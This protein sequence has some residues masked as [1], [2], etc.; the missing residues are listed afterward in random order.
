ML[1][2]K[3]LP[4][5]FVLCII[6]M[7]A[8]ISH[9]DPLANWV[10]ITSGTNHWFYGLTYGNGA[11]VAVG[12]YGT[13]LTSTDGVAWTP[14]TSG[15]S[16][17]LY[18]AGFGNNTFVAVGTIGTILTSSNNGVNWTVRNSGQAHPLSQNL[19]GVTYGNGMFVV[20][21]GQGTILTSSD[22]GVTWGDPSWPYSSPT[23]NWLYGVTYDNSLFI[24]VGATGTILTSTNGTIWNVETSITPAHLEG[25]AYG[26]GT[27]VAVG[28][29]GIIL[30]SP[31]GVNWYQEHPQAPPP[32]LYE[33]PTTDWLRGIAF[34]NGNFVAVG[35]NGN[36]LTS[37]DGTNWTL[38]HWDDSYD[39]E[40]VAYD[41]N[42]NAFAAVGGY[43]TILLDGDTIPEPPVRIEGAPPAYF[44]ALQTAYDSA[45]DDDT[46]QSQAL[47]FNGNLFFDKNI[48][49]KLK[50]GY[51]AMY[52]N[53]PSNTTVNGTLT[54][55][56]GSV[57][58]ENVVIQ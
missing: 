44:S 51:D 21:G 11:F 56:D 2:N 15:D 52:T 10:T 6:V 33:P 28:E 53:N 46:L 54:I 38:R 24:D 19:Y 3:F 42:N 45:S 27:F 31:N 55:S 5:L 25:V 26:N 32:P 20:V 22:N 47:H 30:S 16:H 37:P 7:P 34:D 29:G 49:V 39:L 13:I 40:A 23:A 4:F 12:D 57:I 48:S 58:V 8:G 14:R 35:D 43:G 50:G 1:S 36:I 18:G 9:A 17:H 41:P